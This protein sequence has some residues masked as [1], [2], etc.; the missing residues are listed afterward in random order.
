MNLVEEHEVPHLP[1]TTRLQ[2]YAVNIFFKTPTKS[3]IKKA[4]KKGL[5]FINNERANTGDWLLGG[6]TIFLF[7][8]KIKNGKKVFNLNLEVLFEDEDLAV[9]KKPAGILVSGNS[10]ATISNALTKNLQPSKR[11]DT[12]KPQP[13]HRLDYPTSGVLLIG[14]T[15]KSISTLN[16]LFKN[17]EVK[18]KYIAITIGKMDKEGMIYLPIDKKASKTFYKVLKTVNSVRFKSLNLVLLSPVTGRKHQL[19]K[20]LSEIKNQI[21]GDQK[22][23]IESL[24][25]N[26]KGLYLHAYSI[27]FIHPNTNKKITINTKPSKKFYS[28][29]PSLNELI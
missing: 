13:V 15:S 20:H 3:G 14:K 28:I 29:F 2:D 8:E 1:E 5:I 24:K 17:K 26:G 16:E 23:G 9:I 4:I 21:L 12:V 27:E 25:L 19:R 11:I 6:E 22:Y 18:K 10:F 7:E